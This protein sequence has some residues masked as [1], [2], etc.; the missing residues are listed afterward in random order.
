[1]RRAVVHVITPAAASAS[2]GQRRPQ[3]LVPIDKLLVLCLL[4]LLL[5]LL[6]LFVALL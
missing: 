6:L 2:D 4:L 1:M 3:L 5:L